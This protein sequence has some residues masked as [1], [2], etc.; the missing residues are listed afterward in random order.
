M[1]WQPEID[2]IE[3]RVERAKKMG[4]QE[5]IDVQHG[6]GKLTI[7]ERLVQLESRS[8]SLAVN[9]VP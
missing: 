4:G 2:E 3:K 9:S 6:R 1:V 7:R 8:T 5:G